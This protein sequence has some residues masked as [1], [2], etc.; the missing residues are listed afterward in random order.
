MC[1]FVCVY[2]DVLYIVSAFFL[3]L[4]SLQN[5]MSVH[6]YVKKKDE[7]DGVVSAI[8]ACPFQLCQN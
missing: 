7:Y 1:V 2:H 8:I 4:T 5:L 6:G 3:S